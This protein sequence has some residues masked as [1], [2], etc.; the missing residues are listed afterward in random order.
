[1]KR[2]KPIRSSELSQL[3]LI[4]YCA[5]DAHVTFN[6]PNHPHPFEIKI[7]LRTPLLKPPA[8]LHQPDLQGICELR[9]VEA[10][11]SWSTNP[12]GKA[13][14]ARKYTSPLPPKLKLLTPQLKQDLITA[15]I[16]ITTACRGGDF[17]FRAYPVGTRNHLAYCSL[18]MFPKLVPYFPIGALSQVSHLLQIDPA[19]FPRPIQAQIITYRL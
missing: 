18:K 16:N 11:Y 8:H 19:E 7:S 10:G 6:G 9:A 17:Y 15:V 12:I 14:K 13:P 3:R 1:V 5:P 4:L 2:A